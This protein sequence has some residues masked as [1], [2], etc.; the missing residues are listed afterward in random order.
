[1]GFEPVT[2]RY[3]CDALTNWAM[4][5]LTLG[6]GHLWVLMS[7]WGMD[8]K[9]YIWN[10][11]Y[12]YTGISLHGTVTIAVRPQTEWNRSNFP[13]V[14]NVIYVSIGALMWF[15]ELP[16][17]LSCC[18]ACISFGDLCNRC[19]FNRSWSPSIAV[20]ACLLTTEESSICTIPS[21]SSA[22]SASSS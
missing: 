7:T 4:K 5:P 19:L 6:A 18:M 14:W 8:V 21:S 17:T 2:L 13:T 1:M 22:S 11:S 20:N 10:V 9:W 15:N 12:I 16:Y 3:R